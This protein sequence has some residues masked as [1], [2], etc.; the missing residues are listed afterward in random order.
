MKISDLKLPE[1]VSVKSFDSR[2]ALTNAL[3]ESISQQ[4][5]AAVSAKGTASLAVSGGSTPVPLFQALSKQDLPWTHIITTLVD[6]RWVAPE[7]KDSNEALV[8]THLL[9]NK[10][11]QAP[12]IGLWQANTPAS[13]A[14]AHV[15]TKLSAIEGPLTTV[16]LGM[17]NDGHTAS[18]FPC[19]T[20]LPLAFN[21]DRDCEAVKPT[22]AP[23]SRMTLTPKR[24][25]NS[26]QRILHICGEDKLDTLAKALEIDDPN[27]MPI[28]LFLR[29]PITIYWAP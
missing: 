25:F 6:D 9:Q 5:N 11:A 13:A 1:H 18:L 17:G 24:L 22:T 7:H 16:I 20:Q 15:N 21:S 2:I 29:Q 4:L 14:A 27:T 26:E 28:G 10:A 3:T 12:F 23:H 8:R 19:S